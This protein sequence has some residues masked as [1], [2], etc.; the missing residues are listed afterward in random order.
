MRQN[1]RWVLAGTL[2]LAVAFVVPGIVA[3]VPTAAASVSTLHARSLS[4]PSGHGGRTSFTC[5][6]ISGAGTSTCSTNWGGY[7][8]TAASG[9]VTSVSGSW[10]VP[11]LS[12][13]R[14]GTTY[15]AIWVGIDGYSS[16]TVEQTGVLGECYRGT[17]SYAAWYEFYPA[18]MVAWSSQTVKAGDSV[19]ASVSLSSGVYTVSLTVNSGSANTASATVSGAAS[20]SAEWIVERPS[21]CNAFSCTLSTLANFGT[22][23]FSSASATIG[24]STGSISAGSDVAITMVSGSRGPVLALPSSLGSSGSSFSVTYQ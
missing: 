9:S 1:G 4:F 7:A 22:S 18:G 23:G 11:K 13:P 24:G 14:T 10:T 20:S 21:L 15:V 19:S 3:A 12:C 5:P 17:A 6:T 8:D 16:S 2:L